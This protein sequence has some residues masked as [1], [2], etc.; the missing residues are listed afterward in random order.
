MDLRELQNYF[1]GS[2]G[3][4]KLFAKVGDGRIEIVNEP[5]TMICPNHEQCDIKSDD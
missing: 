1:L 4:E 2:L 3:Q 5:W